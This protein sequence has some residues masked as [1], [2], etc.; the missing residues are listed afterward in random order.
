M[1]LRFHRQVHLRTY[2]AVPY[3]LHARHVLQHFQVQRASQVTGP[4]HHHCANTKEG[5]RLFESGATSVLGWYSQ[6]RWHLTVQS[7][8]TLSQ[9]QSHCLLVLSRFCALLNPQCNHCVNR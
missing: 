3:C 8:V 9:G 6:A 5:L 2:E 4:N 1:D 7:E